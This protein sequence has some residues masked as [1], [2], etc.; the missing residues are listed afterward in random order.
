MLRLKTYVGHHVS[1]RSAT[2]VQVLKPCSQRHCVSRAMHI[3]MHKARMLAATGLS[4]SEPT[5]MFRILAP[6]A[7]L[8]Y[9]FPQA[10]RPVGPSCPLRLRGGRDDQRAGQLQAPFDAAVREQLSP[11]SQDHCSQA[12]QGLC[13]A[14]LSKEA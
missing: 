1:R 8:G 9:G 2:L 5:D 14:E 12:A 13:Y 3:D 11:G 7:I 6:T 4:G 10:A